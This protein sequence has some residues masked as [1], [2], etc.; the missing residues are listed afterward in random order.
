MV[1]RLLYPHHISSSQPTMQDNHYE[2]VTPYIGLL[3]PT[4][5]IDALCFTRSY[6]KGYI[7]SLCFL[8][9]AYLGSSTLIM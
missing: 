9:P 8:T 7:I 2:T 5:A 6:N 4:G 3:H 1:L